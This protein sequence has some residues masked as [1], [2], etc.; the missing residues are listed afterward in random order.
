MFRMITLHTFGPLH[1]LP[2]ASPFITKVELLLKLANVA[3]TSVPSS[4][5]IAPKGKLPFIEDAE[6]KI[7]DSD[8]IRQHLVKHHKAK[9]FLDLT[10]PRGAALWAATRYCEQELYFIMMCQRWLNAR[11]Y[12]HGPSTFF[13]AIPVFVRW[14]IERKV[15]KEMART[16]HGQGM[17]RYSQAELTDMT[18]QGL[19]MLSTLLGDEPYFGGQEPNV[20]DASIYP[21]LLNLHSP[22][23][24]GPYHDLIEQYPALSAYL[25]HMTERFYK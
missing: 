25:T 5:T 6:Q 8:L 19:T 22:E 14:Y 2:D 24:K 11:N 23:F 21:F 7:A 13:K 16:L 1:H 17:S 15:R 18:Q 4:P 9:L 10:T 3:Y 12:A 20:A